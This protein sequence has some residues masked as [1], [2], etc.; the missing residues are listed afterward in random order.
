MK[1]S[2]VVPCFNEEA[3]IKPF[4]DEVLMHAT[5]I[6]GEIEIIFIDDGS[7][8]KTLEKIKVLQ[9]NN[10]ISLRYRSFSRNFG[11]EAAIYAGLEASCGDFVATMD[12][13]LQDPPAL[14][15]EMLDAL[16]KENYDCVATRRVTRN[17]EPPIRSFFARK[18]YSLINKISDVEIIDGARDFRLM[19]RQM[20]NAILSIKEKNR[21]SKGIFSWV[22]FNTKWLEYKNIERKTGE[23]KWSFFKLFLY[24]IEGIT[25]FSTAPLALASVLGITI[26]IIAVC[27]IIVIIAKTLIWGDPV[28]GWPSMLC[29]TLAMG[30]LQLLAI[31]IVGQYLANTYIETKKRPLYIIKEEK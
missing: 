1:I 2:L 12:V 10:E 25:A 5:K 16:T 19:S 11:K 7:T 27:F 3:S 14:L 17:G 13:D 26:F 6:D 22:G 21:F 4:Y 18:F 8:D 20:V 9:K 15:P 31:G 28:A 24:S 30:G 23:T 29:I